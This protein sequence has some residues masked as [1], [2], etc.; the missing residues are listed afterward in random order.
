MTYLDETICYED[1]KEMELPER[2]STPAPTPPLESLK[3]QCVGGAEGETRGEKEGQEALL[4]MQYSPW[5]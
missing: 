4:L 1:P 5:G 2:E 3:S